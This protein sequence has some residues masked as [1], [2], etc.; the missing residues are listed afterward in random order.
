MIGRAPWSGRCRREATACGRYPSLRA[1]PCRTYEKAARTSRGQADER[2]P[3]LIVVQIE[4]DRAFVAGVDLPM[5]LVTTV[6][7]VA[8]RIA[9]RRLDLDHVGAKICK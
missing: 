6:A 8:Q 5:Q 2:H 3:G 7:P 9:P 1:F 4:H